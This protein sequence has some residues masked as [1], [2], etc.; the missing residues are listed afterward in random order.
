[1][2]QAVSFSTSLL[3]RLR[4]ETRAEHRAIEATVEL[5]DPFGSTARYRSLLE[6][7]LG[8]YEP[9]EKALYRFEGRDKTGALIRDLRFLGVVPERIA[10]LPRT[11]WQPAGS[12]AA[13]YGCAY[14]LEG[15]TLGGRVLLRRAKERLGLTPDAGAAFYFGYGDKTR[16]MW[17][18]FGATLL[19]DVSDFYG[20]DLVTSARETFV[21]Y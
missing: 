6:K 3:E 11:T 5:L 19:R 17:T 15:A 7:T 16:E 8:F 21:R 9:V 20:D 14:V 1:M 10:A 2:H 4:N 13:L 18:R 12:L